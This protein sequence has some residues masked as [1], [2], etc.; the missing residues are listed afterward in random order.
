MLAPVL[1]ASAALA[2]AAISAVTGSGV[3]YAASTVYSS[4]S[5]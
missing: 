4:G 3:A 5:V 1:P 2:A